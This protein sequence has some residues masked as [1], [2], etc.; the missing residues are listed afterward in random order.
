[1]RLRTTLVA[2]ITALA[3]ALTLAPPA[4]SATASTY[5]AAAF[6]TT[7][8]HRVEHDRVRLRH[9]T[10]LQRFARRQAVRMAEQERMF[11]QDLGPMMRACHLR[12]GGENVAYGYPSG[13]AVVNRGWMRSPDHRANILERRYRRMA[14]VAR[15]GDNGSWYVSQVF[16]RRF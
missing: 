13:R 15:R 14:I 1:M 16:G 11:H 4:Q 9:D 8:H 3:A 2:G 12:L 5:A 7:N 6:R 10:C